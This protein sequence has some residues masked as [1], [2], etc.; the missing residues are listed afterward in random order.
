MNSALN[1]TADWHRLR[2]TNFFT[3]ED[4]PGAITL[5]KRTHTR[6]FLVGFVGFVWLLPVVLGGGSAI[7]VA[8]GTFMALILGF[9][10]FFILLGLMGYASKVRFT[11]DGVEFFGS[12][13][14]SKGFLAREAMQQ[15]AV[16]TDSRQLHFH[17]FIADDGY[18]SA[19]IG[20]NK[21]DALLM[22]N[23]I[24]A[25]FAQPLE[26]DLVQRATARA[27]VYDAPVLTLTPSHRPGLPVARS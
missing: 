3:I 19:F 17:R 6:K 12:S 26:L 15:I 24:L 4:E 20:N 2:S 21:T 14:R 11:P 5:S 7:G 13:G 27:A 23:I 10:M 1:R 8:V 9:P 18:C 16:E 22:N 25:A